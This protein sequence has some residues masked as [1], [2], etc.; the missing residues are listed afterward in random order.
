MLLEVGQKALG[1]GQRAMEATLKAAGVMLLG[2][3]QQ[4]QGKLWA[5][6]LLS[7]LLHLL[8]M[9]RKQHTGTLLC[10]L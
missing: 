4:L 10:S 3:G 2:A 9:P 6:Q 7:L 5:T 1:E 8:L